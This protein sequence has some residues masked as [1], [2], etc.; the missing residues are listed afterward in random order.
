MGRSCEVIIVHTETYGD[1]S[2]CR[3]GIGGLESAI[4][5]AARYKHQGVSSFVF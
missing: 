4:L 2:M 1:R 3:Q 5:A